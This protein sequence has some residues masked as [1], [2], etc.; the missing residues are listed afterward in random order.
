MRD[1]S[2]GPQS[3]F[4]EIFYHLKNFA[5]NPVQEIRHL[6]NWNWTRVLTM[7]LILSLMSG[8][9][10]ALASSNFSSWKLA[11]GV[12]VFP[13][14]STV[15]GLILASFFYYYFQVFEK[16]TVS[17]IK[18]ATLVFL[19]NTVFYLFHAL[20]GLLV[21]FDILGMTFTGFLLTVGLTD[22]FQ[23]E[24]KR[25]LRLV[26]ALLL[27][28]IVAVWFIRQFRDDRLSR[29]VNSGSIDPSL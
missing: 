23:M 7:Q 8:I 1:V 25:S 15:T 6:P 13:F 18:L 5:R 26:G 17:Y 14:I 19:A 10:S 3:L 27:L 9:L 29:S 28:L 24:K 20:D 12:L 16:R 22:N 21:F 4:Y 2:P 11:Q